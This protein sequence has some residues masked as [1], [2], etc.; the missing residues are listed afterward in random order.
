MIRPALDLQDQ[1]FES[2]YF[3]A[4]YHAL[5][6]VRDREAMRQDTL[7]VAAT[8]LALGLDPA[9]TTLFRQHDVPEI[10]E[11]AWI[12][13][14][15][16]SMGMLERSH[17]YKTAQV[18]GLDANAGL[19]TY[20]VLMAADILA[21]ESEIVPVGRD[22]LQH[23]EIAQDLAQRFNYHFGET[24]K[25]PQPL[26]RENA[27]TVV[28]LDGRKMGKSY[29]NTI[30]LFLPP[31]QLRKLVM[32]IKTNSASLEDPKDPDT[33]NVFSLYRLLA[34]QEE[35]ADLAS[36]YRAGGLGYGHAKK[37][38]FEVLNRT[39]QEPRERYQHLLAHPEEIMEVLDQSAKEA[40]AVARVVTDR[41][42]DAVGL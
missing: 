30:D 18:N 34:T 16:T 41:V 2:Y 28:G 6:S 20:P 31:K 40:R 10:T 39:L 26:I 33:C 27:G 35:I 11:L 22:Q 19:F 17:A 8:F 12:L 42:R 32:S 25:I 13:S 24:F 37:D 23:L 1:G 14:C 5:T 3:I 4:S 36:R 21:F 9:K 7:R 29:G 15:I 38:L